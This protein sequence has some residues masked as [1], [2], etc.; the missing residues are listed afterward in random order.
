MIH[1]MKD[2]T[3]VQSQLESIVYSGPIEAGKEQSDEHGT[4]KKV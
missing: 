2:I 1:M 3:T 4:W